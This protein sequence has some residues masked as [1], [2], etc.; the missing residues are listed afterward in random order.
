M[1]AFLL[2]QPEIFRAAAGKDPFRSEPMVMVQIL[3]QRD[4]AHDSV[5]EIAELGCVEFIDSD[6][7][8]TKT[9]FQRPW[10]TE[11]RLCDDILRQLRLFRARAV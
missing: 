2:G 9:A 7:N 8:E 5:Q 10:V 4:A 6:S 3:M 11:V 1:P